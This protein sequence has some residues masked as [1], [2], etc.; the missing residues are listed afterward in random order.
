MK[1]VVVTYSDFEEFEANLRDLLTRGHKYR[2]SQSAFESFLRLNSTEVVARRY[3][4]LFEIM[5]EE[6]EVEKSLQFLD[7]GAH[8]KSL[9][10]MPSGAFGRPQG[11][12]LQSPVAKGMSKMQNVEGIES[13]HRTMRQ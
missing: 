7:F 4:D 13:R 5:L 12:N 1:E 10:Q 2:A 6:K 11:M 9:D 8:L 3:I